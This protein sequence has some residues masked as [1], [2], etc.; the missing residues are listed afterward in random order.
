MKW[1]A[2][3]LVAALAACEGGDRS[4]LT[5]DSAALQSGTPRTDSITGG[6]TSATDT[7]DSLRSGDSLMLALPKLVLRTDSVAGRTLY[8]GKGK[9]LSC[10]GAAGTGVAGIGSSLQDTVWTNGDGSFAFIQR[11]I[12]DGI[13][14]PKA[15]GPGM[16]AFATTLTF[17]EI[18]RIAAYTYALSHPASVVDDTTRVSLDSL[19]IDTLHRPPPPH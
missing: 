4:D 10:H 15:G 12:M 18:H 8:L 9:C 13:A 7:V 19:I 17:E 1:C 2:A 5:A 6:G 3:V 14:R 16:P 11:A